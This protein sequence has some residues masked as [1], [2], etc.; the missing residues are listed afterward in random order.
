[1]KSIF[2]LSFH[3]YGLSESSLSFIA[4][5]IAQGKIKKNIKSIVLLLI[6]YIVVTIIFF[7]SIKFIAFIFT[8]LFTWSELQV[9]TQDLVDISLSLISLLRKFTNLKSSHIITN[10]NDRYI[11]TINILEKKRKLFIINK[12]PSPIGGEK[13]KTMTTTSSIIKREPEPVE[14][15][16]DLHIK[17]KVLSY[18][19]AEP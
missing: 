18:R 14:I 15:F 19:R 12:C 8:F 7:E 11:S 3:K 4:T 10:F 5:I 13:K 9:N 17:T 16:D 6:G 1:M 2:F